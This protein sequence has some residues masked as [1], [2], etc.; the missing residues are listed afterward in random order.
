L[1]TNGIELTLH[2]NVEY[3]N[4]KYSKLIITDKDAIFDS[5]NPEAKISNLDSKIISDLHNAISYNYIPRLNNDDRTLSPS[6]MYVEYTQ[7]N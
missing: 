2:S 6:T 3:N 4:V 7:L 5:N 1:V